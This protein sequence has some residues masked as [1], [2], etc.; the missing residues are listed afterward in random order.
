[1]AI[2]TLISMRKLIKVVICFFA[3]AAL[4]SCRK[5]QIGSPFMLFEIYGRV[6]DVDA[7]PLEGIHVTSGQS[8]AQISNRNG[9]FTFFGR[10]LPSEHILL[11]FEDKDRDANGG[12]FVKQTVEVPLVL[13]TPGTSGNYKGTFFAGGVEVIMVSK[14][15]DMNPD[16]LITPLVK[17]EVMQ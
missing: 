4:L 10:S 16:S 5:E 9:D 6:M 7:N 11:T 2:I 3:A 8:D 15:L 12:E 13:K 17:P 1:M 14:K